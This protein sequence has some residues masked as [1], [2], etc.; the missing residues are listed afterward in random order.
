M[1]AKC[2]WGKKSG[3]RKDAGQR[4][5]SHPKRDGEDILRFH[6]TIQNDS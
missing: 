3:Q 1:A 5:D 6:H 4:D 2:L